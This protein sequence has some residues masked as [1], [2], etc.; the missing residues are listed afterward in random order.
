[1]WIFETIRIDIFFRWNFI[2]D[3]PIT[4]ILNFTE[5]AQKITPS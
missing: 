4:Y 1:M 5:N 3:H 2:F